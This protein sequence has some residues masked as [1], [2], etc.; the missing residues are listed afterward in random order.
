M[1]AITITPFEGATFRGIEHIQ[2]WRRRGEEKAIAALREA[3]AAHGEDLADVITPAERAYHLDWNRYE[4]HREIDASNL[5]FGMV[6]PGVVIPLVFVGIAAAGMASGDIATT[7][8]LVGY[9]SASAL[10][11]AMIVGGP[12]KRYVAARALGFAKSFTERN[13]LFPN[14]AWSLSEDALYVTENRDPKSKQA[15]I[16]VR[17]IAWSELQHATWRKSGDILFVDVADR[18]G[19]YY[20]MPEPKGS[21]VRGAAH[22]CELI[23]R[24][25]AEA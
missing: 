13:T 19:D 9:L 23:N 6:F 4:R 8:E 20:M 16:A 12:L 10:F 22:F 11:A 7:S 17:R 1:T 15:A 5:R 25:I 3:A 18:N 24:R 2:D 21:S 14:H